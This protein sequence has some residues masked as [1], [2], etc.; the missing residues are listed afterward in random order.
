M[1]GSSTL[2]YA[3]LLPLG[4]MLSLCLLMLPGALRPGV[5]P[6]DAGRA[7]FCYAAQTM[8]ILLMTAGG[9]PA[10][11]AVLASQ[12]LR[13]MMYSG[14][15]LIFAL[16]GIVYLTY[17]SIARGVEPLS[18]AFP[19]TIFFHAWKL[20]GL[21]AVLFS[22]S[23]LLLRL[24]AG[25]AADA[26]WWVFYVVLLVY[27]G[28]LCWF[29]QSPRGFSPAFRSTSMMQPATTKTASGVA[30]KRRK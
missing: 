8:G 6:E 26:R 11:Y 24:A 1:I 16:G 27:G 20:L 21:A 3:L 18:R 22:V 14:L 17:D 25:G 28:I 10:L 19:A 2:L 5:K 4:A 7:A 15:L 30:K 23:G 13:G 9:M 29:T 12:P